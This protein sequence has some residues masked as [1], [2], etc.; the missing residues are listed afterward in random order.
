[1]THHR[2]V[3]FA[4]STH[5]YIQAIAAREGISFTAALHLLIAQSGQPTIKQTLTAA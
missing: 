1:M 4:S 2:S 5:A 3:R